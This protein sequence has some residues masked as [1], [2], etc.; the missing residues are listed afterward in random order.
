[1]GAATDVLIPLRDGPAVPEAVVLWLL[2]AE[3]RGL[4]F[5]ILQDGSLHVVPER[6]ITSDDDRFIREHR[7]VVLACVRYCEEPPPC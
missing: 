7:D 5:H 3:R 1:M 2:D 4:R 6:L